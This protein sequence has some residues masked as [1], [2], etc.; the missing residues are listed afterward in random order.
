MTVGNRY[1]NESLDKLQVAVDFLKDKNPNM[2]I[3]LGDIIDKSETIKEELQCIEK[4]KSKLNTLCEEQHFVLGNH[5]IS[6][7]SKGEFLD[8]CG[9]KSS[10]YSFDR[11]GMHIVILDSNFNSDGTAFAPDNITGS[12]YWIDEKQI[13]WLEN[14]L[15]LV[16]QMPTLVFCHANLDHRIR[17]DGQLNGHIVKNAAK[18]RSVLER[19]GNV[20]L[21]IQGHDHRGQEQTINSI[22]YIVLHAMVEGSGYEQNAFAFLNVYEDGRFFL[23][24]YGRQPS[25]SVQPSAEIVAQPQNLFMSPPV[26][27]YAGAKGFTLSI[28]CAQRVKGHVEWG[29]SSDALTNQVIAVHGGLAHTH[30]KG[31][32]ID[33]NFE[34]T[35][36]AE[37]PIYYR[38]VAQTI[39]YINAYDIALGPLVS[40]A[41]R[42]LT[43]PHPNQKTITLA[44]VND[45]HNRNRTLPKLAKQIEKVNPDLL[46][47]N[48]DVCAEFNHSDNSHAILLHPGA[49]GLTPSCDG[50]ASTR[51]LLY[52]PGN[53]DVR[54]VRANELRTIFPPGKNSRL[55]YNKAQRI[56]PLAIITLDAGEDK[57]DHHPI[58]A[59]TAAYE[60]YR[61][62]QAEW[63]AEQLKLPEI[64]NAPFKIAFS[65]IPLRG[66]PGQSDGS[67]LENGARYSGQGALLWLPQLIEAKFNAVIS[68]H[69]HQW[70][71]D[72]ANQKQAITQIVG[73]GPSPDLAT[74]IVIA[75]NA[76]SMHISTK[77]LEGK[78]LGEQ[79]WEKGS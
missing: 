72:P 25:F 15:K 1:C 32:V 20:K 52:V 79:S 46:V 44:V 21:V 42:K 35:I 27:L 61:E 10:Y 75:V 37:Q 55:P 73:G 5:D 8:A 36:A 31:M 77:N 60:P 4:V 50:W 69:T 78:V 74:V 66:L 40:T 7:L 39:D 13:E 17:K 56:G 53:H 71:Y 65:H 33:V 70:R 57:P 11:E 41:N 45:T 30:E 9:A 76:L 2:I 43:L 63:L 28:E 59:G 23:E 18:V 24:G 64:A 6:E 29:F 49:N 14:D 54:G 68:G 22:P 34:Q 62:L 16:A 3:C 38:V 48:G 26:I 51:P 12:G 47:W 67:T 19:S 58:F